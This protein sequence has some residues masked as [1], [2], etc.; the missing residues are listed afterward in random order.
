MKAALLASG[1]LFASAA[2]DCTLEPVGGDGGGIWVETGPTWHLY[3]T[4]SAP[5]DLVMS[6]KTIKE[7]SYYVQFC[8]TKH[9]TGDFACIVQCKDG[10][11]DYDTHCYGTPEEHCVHVSESKMT[12]GCNLDFLSDDEWGD[13]GMSLKQHWAKVIDLWYVN[14]ERMTE[15]MA[16]YFTSFPGG[17]GMPVLPHNLANLVAMGLGYELF[18]N[19]WNWDE[20]NEMS[21]DA[22]NYPKY[23]TWEAINLAAYS[24]FGEGF[25]GFVDD[26][27]GSTGDGKRFF[28]DFGTQP[29]FTAG[30]AGDS[31][32]L[33]LNKA[34]PL[35][36]DMRPTMLATVA[37]YYDPCDKDGDPVF[38]GLPKACFHIHQAGPHMG[39]GN[40]APFYKPLTD[41]TLDFSGVCKSGYTGPDEY[42]A[43]YF[44]KKA[45]YSPEFQAMETTMDDAGGYL[46]SH[47]RTWGLHFCID[48]D[49]SAV[50][51]YSPGAV[52][53]PWPCTLTTTWME[54]PNGALGDFMLLD[55][56]SFVTD[57]VLNEDEYCA[58]SKAG[59]CSKKITEGAYT[60]AEISV[61]QYDE[62]YTTNAVNRNKG[63]F[64]NQITK[65]GSMDTNA[66]G[67]PVMPYVALGLAYGVCFGPAGHIETEFA[68]EETGMPEGTPYN[69]QFMG[70]TIKDGVKYVMNGIYP[71]TDPHCR[72]SSLV[73]INWIKHGEVEF[74]AFSDSINYAWVQNP[75]STLDADCASFE[76][77]DFAGQFA[78]GNAQGAYPGGD[79]GVLPYSMLPAGWLW[80]W[81]KIGTGDGYTKTDV[82]ILDQG[83]FPKNW[84]QFLPKDD[85]ECGDDAAWN[86]NG[87]PE[88]DCAWVAAYA[89]KRCDTMGEDKVAAKDGCK[90]ACGSCTADYGL[91]TELNQAVNR[92]F[93]AWEYGFED[94]YFEGY[95]AD[96]QFSVDFGV[97]S[98]PCTDRACVW[99]FRQS[100]AN[101]GFPWNLLAQT[102][103]GFGNHEFVYKLNTA[104]HDCDPATR[105]VFID[106]TGIM[107][108]NYGPTDLAFMGMPQVP[109]LMAG[110]VMQIS[111]WNFDF[112][113]QKKVIK[114]YQTISYNVAMDLMM[115]LSW[116]PAT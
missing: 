103:N 29:A 28:P 86:K 77:M 88:K 116:F 8:T 32:I 44:L 1:Y 3:T 2:A 95:P 67:T 73:G 45:E 78:L 56:L 91:C 76:T 101:G 58:R 19:I 48:W 42:G 68:A 66:D 106:I 104:N 24:P 9:Y 34:F 102:S 25:P 75:I 39:N 23:F 57:P 105:H 71:A 12:K 55:P 113:E 108:K 83:D 64:Y 60:A 14:T 107:K 54:W 69:S 38:M 92:A 13:T 79:F 84:L 47:T 16:Q 49:A 85:A 21:M 87:A 20:N 59:D 112:N 31:P 63:P 80:D 52:Y 72:A 26:P 41:G 115:G 110:T 6:E 111:A 96:G 35:E 82:M 43:A 30:A 46:L 74:D 4:S 22:K 65:C 17:S 97:G 114:A 50:D 33:M 70:C 11:L 61:G 18:H 62:E 27:Y 89:E 94:E 53:N 36:W 81:T 98:A 5:R 109:P 93:R 15:S 37:M 99:G 51:P 100:T 90:A 10:K 7:D 40:M